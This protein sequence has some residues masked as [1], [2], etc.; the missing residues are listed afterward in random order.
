MRDP[1]LITL[2]KNVV[3]LHH[4]A[5]ANSNLETLK[6]EMRDRPQTYFLGSYEINVN[7][8]GGKIKLFAA[9]NGLLIEFVEKVKKIALNF[10]FSRLFEQI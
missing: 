6:D 10:E 7:S 2:Q 8:F 9:F 5:F 3:G 1:Q 4:I